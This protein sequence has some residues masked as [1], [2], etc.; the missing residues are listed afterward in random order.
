MVDNSIDMLKNSPQGYSGQPTTSYKPCHDRSYL[1]SSHI[2]SRL[3]NDTERRLTESMPTEDLQLR[4]FFAPHESLP[5]A[6]ENFLRLAHEPK[7]RSVPIHKHC[8]SRCLTKGVT[9]NS[10]LWHRDRSFISF[11][12]LLLHPAIASAPRAYVASSQRPQRR[13]PSL[14]MTGPGLLRIS[15]TVRIN[16]FPGLKLTGNT[17][18]RVDKT[19][20]LHLL[21]LRLRP[22]S[23]YISKLH[24]YCAVAR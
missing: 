10:A 21:L 5:L 14:G 19:P 3:V 1:L 8:E 15:S 13:S 17:Q 11:V 24:H 12:A 16:L 23:C 4:E 9:Q 6:D 7:L 18:N 20:Q 22:F 2:I